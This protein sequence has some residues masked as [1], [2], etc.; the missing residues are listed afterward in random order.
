MRT[1]WNFFAPGQIVFGNGAVAQ[2]GELASR[3]NLQRV[4]VVADERLSAAGIVGRVTRSLAEA[5]R[6]VEIFA[7][8]EPEPSVDLAVQ[9]AEVAKAFR[10]DCIL[11]LGGGSNMDLAKI[12]AVLV[13]HGGRPEKFFS[14]NNVPGPVLPL[15]CVPTTAGTGSEVSHAAVLTDTANQIKVST[16]SQFLRPAIAV[17]DPELTMTCPPKVTADSG[18]DALTHAIE[19]YT[20]VECSQLDAKNGEPVAY[21][22]C[23]PLGAALAEKA[24]ELVG[25]HLVTAAKDGLN[26]AA[27][28]GMA[29]AATLAGLA[30]SHSAVALVHALEYPL[31][32]V[33]HCSHGA[34]NGLLLPYVMRFNLPQRTAAFAR[35]AELLG[36]DVRGLP[37]ED[38]AERAVIAVEKLRAAIGI[39]QRIREIGGTREQLPTFA[40]RAFAIKRLLA[41]NP[42][43]ASEADLR[44]IL[45]AAY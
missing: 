8:G 42:R 10:P 13:T 3:R 37:A 41:V 15:V 6:D 9:A 2:V 17:V 40:A 25:K 27:R 7:G 21:E 36:E 11:G 12:V 5:M 29:L 26:P 44:G 28:E 38:A 30:F 14:F 1:T 24:L 20:A 16:L 31:G 32:G 35:I 43:P 4:F 18:I 22:G 45:E 23:T 33:L 34:G 19:A 39:P